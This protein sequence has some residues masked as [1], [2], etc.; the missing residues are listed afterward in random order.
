MLR[1]DQINNKAFHEL[2]LYYMRERITH[3]NLEIKHL[4]VTNISNKNRTMKSVL[5]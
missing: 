1:P 3:K 5:L 4:I 2:V